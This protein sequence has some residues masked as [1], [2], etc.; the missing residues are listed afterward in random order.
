MQCMR[1]LLMVAMVLAVLLATPLLVAAQ[2]GGQIKHTV[3]VGENLYRIARQYGTTMT[4]IA[5]AN[6]ITNPN[7]ILVGQVLVIPVSAPVPTP[8]GVPVVTATPVSP[9][10]SEI[11]H[12]VRP[13]ENL[14]RISLQYNLLT[15]IV[16]A[17]NG[18]TN[19]NLIYVGQ[20]IRIPVGGVVA[21]PVATV[22]P[23]PTLGGPAPTAVGPQP[24]AVPPVATLP[25][26]AGNVGFA[27]GVQVH[28]PNQDM[29][30]VMAAAT[31]LGVTWVK[32]Q[33]EWSLY[34][35]TPGNINWTPLDEM[36][37]A[38]DNAGV[39]ILLNITSAPGWARD[40]DQE[41]GPPQDYN[42]FANFVGQVAERYKGRVDAYEIWHEPNLRREWNTPNGRSAAAYVELLKLAYTAIKLADPEAVVVSAGLGPTGL[43]DNVN[44]VDDRVFLRQ[45]Y[46]AGVADWSDAIGVHPKGWANPADSVCCRNNRPA[47]SGWDDHPSF[48]FKQTLEDYRAIMVQNGDSRTY[49]WATEF[50]WGSNDGLGVEPADM[51]N[52]GFVTFTSQDEQAQYILR[53]FQVGRESNYVGPMFLWNLNFCQ[54]AGVTDTQCFWSMLDPTGNP[55]APYLALQDLL[56]GG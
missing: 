51:A 43:N 45:M 9:P 56:S 41:K 12:V 22:T 34:E 4:A 46:A 54:A 53:A 47:V 55:R 40:S 1:R 39:N 6:N 10:V 32:E 25:N 31:N 42:T 3:Q 33:I 35:A 36:V 27:Y 13:G 44:A 17:Y 26:Q 14:F 8:T 49:L 37:D 38:M 16:A 28:L 11:I 7:L 48:F 23:V 21:A 15:S 30:G 50:G 19:P 20:Q 52:F 5:Q 24:T 2:D 18:I 29:T